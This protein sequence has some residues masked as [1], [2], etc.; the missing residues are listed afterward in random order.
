ML[1]NLVEVIRPLEIVLK[2]SKT[3]FKPVFES[4]ARL[5]PVFKIP[6]I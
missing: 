6:I 3:G 4:L 1:N 5:K 2:L